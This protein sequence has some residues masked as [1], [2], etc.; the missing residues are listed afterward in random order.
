MTG[1]VAIILGPLG[2]NFGSGMTGG[3]AYVLRAKPTMCFNRD[4]V[5][6]S[7]I[8]SDE[9]C[10]LRLTLEETPSPHGKSSRGSLALATGSLQLMRVQPRCI[11]SGAPAEATSPVRPSLNVRETI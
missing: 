11:I 7:E 2:L 1:G 5:T 4:F 3:L 9:E 8:D 6:S 10:W